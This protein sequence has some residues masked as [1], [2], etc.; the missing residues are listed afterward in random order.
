[1]NIN[2]VSV[3]L[4][5]NNYSG[6]GVTKFNYD[7]KVELMY[8]VLGSNVK[9]SNGVNP[10]ALPF[11][12]GVKLSDLFNEISSGRVSIESL[13]DQKEVQ[14][15]IFNYFQDYKIN[16]NS[17]PT[18]V[19]IVEPNEILDTIMVEAQIIEDK[20]NTA[21]NQG[22]SNKEKTALIREQRSLMNNSILPMYIEAAI[23]ANVEQGLPENI[24][25]ELRVE[26]VKLI[27]PM[28]TDNVLWELSGIPDTDPKSMA[29]WTKIRNNT[30]RSID[31]FLT[32]YDMYNRDPELLE[33]MLIS[34]GKDNEEE[35]KALDVK[36]EAITATLDNVNASV[37]DI[38]AAKTEKVSVLKDQRA[39]LNSTIDQLVR[40]MAEKLPAVEIDKFA[41]GAISIVNT[42]VTDDLLWNLSSKP[43]ADPVNIDTNIK[44]EAAI[45]RFAVSFAANFKQPEL[46][47]EEVAPVLQEGT[48]S[49]ELPVANYTTQYRPSQ[50]D[51]N[52]LWQFVQ[53]NTLVAN[54][55][56]NPIIERTMKIFSNKEL[57]NAVLEKAPTPIFEYIDV[58]AANDF[59]LRCWLYGT[60]YIV[61]HN[62]G[63]Q[64]SFTEYTH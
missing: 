43:D 18:V 21:K 27:S 32:G 53:L 16:G 20:I 38:A 13:S 7:Q 8:M 29:F 24:I 37:E 62:T 3:R 9:Y 48:I 56:T 36:S 19:E 40:K 63:N 5:G 14:D 52:Y 41:N 33:E 15:M 1:M 22:V 50:D 58:V 23:S 28:L 25:N 4:N 10:L 17:S 12:T 57:F 26:L 55:D 47:V 42:I 35:C 59:K 61:L 54:F 39:I 64:T 30:E 45:Q 44:I 31:N 6:L 34:I 11:T 2:D 49:Q 51:I 46:P 60:T